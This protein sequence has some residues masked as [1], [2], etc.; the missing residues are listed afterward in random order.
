ML[1]RSIDPE[2]TAIVLVDLR[3]TASWMDANPGCRHVNAFGRESNIVSFGSEVFYRACSEFMRKLIDRLKQQDYYSRIV[4]FQPWV[5]GV[6]DSCMGGVEENTWQTDRTK[7][8]AG[9]FNPGALEKFRAFLRERYGNDG[10]RLRRAW[11]RNDVTFDNA[12][13]EIARLVAEPPAGEVLRDPA[14][15]GMMAFDYADFLPTLLGNFQRRLFAEVKA[16]TDRKKMTF[17]HYGFIVEHM[18]GLNTPAG[19]LNDNNYDLPQ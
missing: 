8:T 11:R 16:A 7:L 1:F 2:G 18:R 6:P 17:T 12:A 15:E 5:C 19:G 9:D 4:G 14:V 10:E 3:P 13:P